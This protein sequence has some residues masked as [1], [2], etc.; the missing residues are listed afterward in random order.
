M[1]FVFAGNKNFVEL[2]LKVED[3]ST[4]ST[5]FFFCLFL[6]VAPVVVSV[7]SLSFV[8]YSSFVLYVSS[9]YKFIPPCLCRKLQLEVVV[10]VGDWRSG[11][12]TKFS[13]SISPLSSPG[14]PTHPQYPQYI[15][16]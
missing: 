9:S 3:F 7:L 14:L 16:F 4:V 15:N 12:I 11:S 13:H 5:V 10:R 1:A 6:S 2:V 8:M